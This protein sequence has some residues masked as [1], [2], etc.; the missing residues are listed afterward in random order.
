MASGPGSLRWVGEENGGHF[1]PKA[2]GGK[3]GDE[4]GRSGRETGERAARTK[5]HGRE[6]KMHLFLPYSGRVG[7][8]LR[9]K[10][11]ICRRKVAEAAF[12]RRHLSTELPADERRVTPPEVSWTSGKDFLEVFVEFFGPKIEQ[13]NEN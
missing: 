6:C 4:D 1:E 12:Q 2:S 9:R 3:R 8:Y 10:V 7:K 5:N 11:D 13:G